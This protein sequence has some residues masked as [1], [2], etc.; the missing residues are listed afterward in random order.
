MIY[1][2]TSV[3]VSL[4]CADAN[5]ALATSLLQ[6]VNERLLISSLCEAEAVNAFSL[7]QFRK[8]ITPRQA[9]A[10]ARHLESDLRSQV[11]HLASLPPE[12]FART[13]ALSRQLTP[14]LGTRTADLL[15]VAAALE[16]GADAFFTFAVQQR[17]AAIAAGLKTNP[18]P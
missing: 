16:L 8:E 2:D 7:R 5:S 3:L 17:K 15:H 10:S 14:R 6:N 4:Y 13:R 1:I 18:A 12:A 9:D 11:F